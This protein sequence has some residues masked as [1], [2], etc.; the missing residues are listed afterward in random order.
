M[1]DHPAMERLY[2]ERSIWPAVEAG[3]DNLDIEDDGAPSLP[4]DLS[5]VAQHLPRTKPGAYLSQSPP[6]V[7]DLRWLTFP[8][9]AKD[10]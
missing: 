2:G 3:I 5:V 10:L 6:L 7:F 1:Q 8:L 4:T 9:L